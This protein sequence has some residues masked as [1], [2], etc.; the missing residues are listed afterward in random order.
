MSTEPDVWGLVQK[1]RKGDT[2]SFEL[3]YRQH[4]GRVHGLC[5]RLTGT[6]TDAEEMTQ[7]VFVR[8]WQNIDKFR[9]RSHFPA[10]LH[11]VA[12]N[13]AR[14][15]WRTRARW[16]RPKELDEERPD[17]QAPRPR[18]VPELRADLEAAIEQLPRGAREVF[19]LH[20]VHGYRH[21]EIAEMNGLAVGTT[22]AQLHRAR[23]RLREV[24][25]R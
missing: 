21:D 7:E 20:D 4:V 13:L 12:V 18:A 9:N 11:R 6:E 16:G 15:E 5:L 24:L 25:E 14:N 2:G 3:L 1:A 8:A 22:K 19:L 10:W 23:K 17:G